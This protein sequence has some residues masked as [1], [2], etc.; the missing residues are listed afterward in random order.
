MRTASGSSK[1][2][3]AASSPTCPSLKGRGHSPNLLHL[4]Y[5]TPPLI[6]QLLMYLRTLHALLVLATKKKGNF[7]NRREI[8]YS[9][10]TTERNHIQFCRREEAIIFNGQM[11]R[12]TFQRHVWKESGVCF[13]GKP[14]Y[15]KYTNYYQIR[16]P[17]RNKIFLEHPK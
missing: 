1:R 13:A 7:V 3:L 6:Q 16:S 14:L 10:V 15:S 9:R 5:Q 12:R 11:I 17:K 8:G 2:E 4:L